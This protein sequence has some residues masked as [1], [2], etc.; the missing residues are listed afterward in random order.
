MSEIR[1][2]ASAHQMKEF[3]NL[4]VGIACN[5][6]TVHSVLWVNPY[7]EDVNSNLT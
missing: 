3:E 7:K 1:D 4:S 6:Q 2:G 5:V